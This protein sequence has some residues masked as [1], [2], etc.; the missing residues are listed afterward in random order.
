MER[1]MKHDL[2]RLFN[3]F[4]GREVLMTETTQTRKVAGQDVT[5]TTVSPTNPKDPVIEEMNQLAKNNGLKLRVWFP[6]T[7]GTM[8]ARSDRMNV[9]VEKEADGKYRVSKKFY[10]G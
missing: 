2:T 3:K 6:N 9:R 1:K 7:F 4:A 8:D 10:I 5:Y